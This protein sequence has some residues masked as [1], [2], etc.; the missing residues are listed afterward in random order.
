MSNKSYNSKQR[1]LVFCTD[2][3]INDP[4]VKKLATQMGVLD[5][6]SQEYNEQSLS[7][8]LENLFGFHKGNYDKELIEGGQRTR[9]GKLVEGEHRYIGS[10]R[11]DKEWCTSSMASQEAKEVFKFG[12]IL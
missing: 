4:T 8:V 7:Y 1:I 2:S 3:D 12:E 5:K 11:L 10:E 9:F 6:P